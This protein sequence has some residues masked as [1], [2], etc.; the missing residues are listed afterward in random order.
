MSATSKLRVTSECP[1]SAC[2]GSVYEW[3]LKQRKE[4]ADPWENISILPN[5]TSTVVNATDM[6]IKKN[7][8]PSGF[9]FSLQLFVTSQ[10]GSEGFGVLE[11]E[12]AGVPHG[13]FCAKSINEGVALETEFTFECFEWEDKNAP[14]TYE[15]RVGK[16]IISY[17]RSPKSRPTVL[18][19]G[20]QES[21]YQLQINIIIKN[22]IGVAVEEKAFVKVT[23]IFQ[24][25]AYTFANTV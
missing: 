24:I 7:S 2:N 3:R 14:I 23:F 22:S 12:T 13:G 21:D 11:L 15:F 20:Q 4:E 9:Y 25:E 16:D 6:I 19:A 10:A 1:N 5:M 18:A 8:L 17:G